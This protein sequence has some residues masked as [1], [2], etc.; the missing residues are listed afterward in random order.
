MLRV[1]GEGGK[2]EIRFRVTLLE[3]DEIVSTLSSVDS[4]ADV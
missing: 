4:V 2:D 3:P 1:L